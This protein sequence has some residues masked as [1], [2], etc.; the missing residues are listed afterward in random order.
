[1]NFRR[2][3]ARWAVGNLAILI[4][5]CGVFS[6]AGP[7]LDAKS[8]RPKPLSTLENQDTLLLIGRSVNRQDRHV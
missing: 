1:M 3:V 5:V 8:V 7:S 4:V 6:A 2:C